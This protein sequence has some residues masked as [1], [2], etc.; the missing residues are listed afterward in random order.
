MAKS[1]SKW[2]SLLYAKK[3]ELK[4]QTKKALEMAKETTEDA[5]FTVCLTET[6]KCGIETKP[7]DSISKEKH[8]RFV[9]FRSFGENKNDYL[10]A[11]DLWFE[12]L[13]QKTMD[14]IGEI[15]ITE[16]ENNKGVK[17]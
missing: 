13:W 2:S 9:A 6:G 12:M 5:F 3:E 8:L 11:F 17:E 10:K 16:I 1:P 15:V 4:T 14:C 7:G